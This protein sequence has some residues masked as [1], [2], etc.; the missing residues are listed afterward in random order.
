MVFTYY[1]IGLTLPRDKIEEL[2]KEFILAYFHRN[3]R[4]WYISNK[5]PHSLLEDSD[6]IPYY[7]PCDGHIKN[8][9]GNT[10]SSDV[11]D[12]VLMMRAYCQQC[13]KDLR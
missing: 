12:G 8:S 1:H 10:Q 7:T 2:S 9:K 6:I 4:M 13:R 11:I 3:I 5:L